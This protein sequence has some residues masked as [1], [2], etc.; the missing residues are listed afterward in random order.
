MHLSSLANLLVQRAKLIVR[1][2]EQLSRISRQVCS[3][4]QG[5]SSHQMNE[6]VSYRE[7]MEFHTNMLACGNM[8]VGLGTTLNIWRNTLLEFLQERRYFK[9]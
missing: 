3:N 9:P 6:V 4:F 8:H 1:E 5:V 7:V 2:G